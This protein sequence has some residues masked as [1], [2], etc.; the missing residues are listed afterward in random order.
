M[1]GGSAAEQRAGHDL[2]PGEGVAADQLVTTPMVSGSWSGDGDEGERVD[3]RRPAT[4]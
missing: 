1:S 4:P 2:A 3:E